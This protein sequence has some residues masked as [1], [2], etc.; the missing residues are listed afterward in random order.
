M[1]AKRKTNF[2]AV[3][4]PKHYALCLWNS[5][6]G[7]RR[8]YA[9]RDV[10][11]ST[12][13][14]GFAH[15]RERKLNPRCE[16]RGMME[17]VLPRPSRYAP[18]KEPQMPKC[19]F[20]AAVG[21][22]LCSFAG[23]QDHNRYEL[24]LV[25]EGAELTRTLTVWRVP[26]T[27]GKDRFPPA[28][29]KKIAALYPAEIPAI[30]GRHTF[31]ARFGPEMP[32]DV[33]GSGS[34]H[35]TVTSLGT[36]AIYVEQFRGSDDVESHI[37]DRRRAADELTN[38]LI[39]WFQREISRDPNFARIRRFL[40][41]DFRRDLRNLSHY[42]AMTRVSSQ[43]QASLHQEY[44]VRAAM[45][46][47]ERGYFRID[48]MP[49]AVHVEATNDVEQQVRFLIDLLARKIAPEEQTSI[50]RSLRF[51]SDISRAENS[52]D[53]YLRSTP[54]FRRR[55]QEWRRAQ[56]TNPS[57]PPPD[58]K[59]IVLELVARLFFGLDL[60]S[61][62]DEL[63]VALSVPLQP[64][65]TNGTYLSVSNQVVW[66]SSLGH[67]NQL[68]VSTYAAW[69]VPDVQFQ[70]NHFGDIVLRG[71]DLANYVAWYT[72]LDEG[73]RGEWDDF[74]SQLRPGVGLTETVRGFRFSRP[75]VKTPGLATAVST[76]VSD[77]VKKLL[78]P[79]LPRSARERP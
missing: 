10:R 43:Q 39:G 11:E 26:E 36:A 57:A 18:P 35:Y 61:Q 1:A 28:E 7:H 24:E 45:Y 70:E 60:V 75:T 47:V 38:L 37:D 53:A 25:P 22:L 21:W 52:L 19:S 14:A 64:F 6:S 41:E 2:A 54:Q 31:R 49:A 27:R 74:L 50:S 33:G 23:C 9:A 51:L 58:G 20:A 30:A 48:E 12:D 46:L 17:G 3:K 44:W 16:H 40:D 76:D 63:R 65:A 13:S 79:N 67:E 34:Y 68:P 62:N 59:D 56:T 73:E 66:T 78:L 55:E 5:F 15:R 71:E 29:L 4:P 72:G 42:W 8:W 77:Y 69:S 32:D